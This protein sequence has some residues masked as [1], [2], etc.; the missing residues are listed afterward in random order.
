M[1]SELCANR[2]LKERM[3]REIRP[4]SQWSIA[5][6]FIFFV[7]LHKLACHKGFENSILNHAKLGYSIKIDYE[8]VDIV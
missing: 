3:Q 5:G 6:L 1:C 7:G 8:K 2:P 4:R